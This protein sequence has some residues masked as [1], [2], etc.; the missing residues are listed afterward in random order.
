MT[1]HYI[2]NHVKGADSVSITDSGTPAVGAAGDAKL[3][4]NGGEVVVSF[5]GAAY[6]ALQR[7]PLT[8]PA[9]YESDLAAGGLAAALAALP[10]R[11]DAD[12]YLRLPSGSFTAATIAGFTGLG[13]IYLVGARSAATLTSGSQSGTADSGT[14]STSLVKPTAA[15]DWTASNLVGKFLYLTGG[16]GAGSDTTNAPVLSPIRANTTTTLTVE[17]IDGMDSTTTFEIVDLASYPDALMT[18]RD[19]LAPVVFR[20]VKFSTAALTILLNTLRANVTLEGCHLAA[21][22]SDVTARLARGDVTLDRCYLSGSSTVSVEKA[23]D[24]V[25]SDCYG[26]GHNGIS[27]SDFSTLDVT[28]YRSVSS[29]GRALTLLRGDYAAVEAQ[30]DSS[31]STP[32]YFESIAVGISQGS[33]H[34][35]GSNDTA[36]V[37]GLQLEGTGYWYVTGSTVTGHRSSSPVKDV[38]RGG[39][40]ELWSNLTSTTYGAAAG[41]TGLVQA[42][43]TPG[44]L[45][46]R[47]NRNYTGSITCGG[48]FLTQ[49]T[50]YASFGTTGARK[51]ATGTTIDDALTM[52]SSALRAGIIVGTTAAG[53]GVMLSSITTIPGAEL[54]VI[55]LGAN[56][57][58]VYPA[59]RTI[60]AVTYIGTIDGGA[61]GAPTTVAAGKSKTFR[62]L[63]TTN[64]VALVDTACFDVWTVGAT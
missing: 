52:E 5:E 38:L 63:D 2:G 7:A 45:I 62:T 16:G 50:L 28:K 61:Q 53:T 44:Q 48:Y 21:S 27:V 12:A 60:N 9:D 8:S 56:T 22:G 15:S 26:S 41:F 33:L 42:H 49:G 10:Q 35:A 57:L 46:A 30:A 20:G 36:G 43:S 6:Q 39:V 3:A 18:V 64:G 17:A 47:G 11:L 13:T 34:L 4:Y 51:T 59:K 1:L 55:N 37:Y 32:F 14:T 23:G 31:G 40:A 54:T 25:L 58:N 24:V 19:C 29:V